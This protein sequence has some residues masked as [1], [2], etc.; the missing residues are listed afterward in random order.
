[1]RGRGAGRW[2]MGLVILVVAMMAAVVAVMLLAY[3]TS[4]HTASRTR[5]AAALGYEARI[6]CMNAVEEG[7]YHFITRSNSPRLSKRDRN[8]DLYKVFRDALAA[9]GS[10]A[11]VS[12]EYPVP[13]VFSRR[14]G[15]GRRVTITDVQV[16]VQAQGYERMTEVVQQVKYIASDL[17]AGGPGS[18]TGKDRNVTIRATDAAQAEE[19]RRRVEAAAAAGTYQA[20]QQQVLQGPAAPW[21]DV[22][23]SIITFEP[24]KTLAGV[25]EFDVTARIEGP[26]AVVERRMVQRRTVELTTL[27]KDAPIAVVRLSPNRVF[28]SLSRRIMPREQAAREA[29]NP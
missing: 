3:G 9:D 18:S 24:V 20:L 17:R 2:G 12:L 23:V 13:P 11:P 10:V 14:L 5:G 1:M 26:H 19:A 25:V 7:A 28:T 8:V 22:A 6:A 16:R 29:A 15:H 27:T 21:C 4:S